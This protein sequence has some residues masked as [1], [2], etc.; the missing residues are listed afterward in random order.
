[1]SPY[2][3]V[4]SSEQAL[5]FY[6]RAFGFQ[7]RFAMARPDGRLGHVEMTWQE[8]LLMFG[9]ESPEFPCQVPA[10]SGTSSP[11]SLYVYCDDVDTL[12]ARATAA[13]AEAVRPPED[14][15]WGDR[16]CQLRDPD[17]YLWCFATHKGANGAA[18]H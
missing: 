17:G 1:L 8:A 7:K 9:P 13:G 6:E 16:M 14:Q 12:F 3:A 15:F 2:L 5:E 18:G 11:L 4:K 10:S